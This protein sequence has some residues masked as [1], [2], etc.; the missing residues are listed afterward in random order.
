MS[1]GVGLDKALVHSYPDN[2]HS[3]PDAC[4]PVSLAINTKSAKSAPI[5]RYF[6]T[7]CP[8]QVLSLQ[9][10]FVRPCFQFNYLHARQSVEI[11]AIGSTF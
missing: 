2:E 7:N 3:N 4:C 6:K 8:R 9:D 5:N 1:L 11:V 10:S